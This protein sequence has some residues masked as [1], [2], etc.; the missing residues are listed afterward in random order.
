LISR[1][2]EVFCKNFQNK[3]IKKRLKR[4]RKEEKKEAKKG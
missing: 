3:E 4:R 2:R 1:S